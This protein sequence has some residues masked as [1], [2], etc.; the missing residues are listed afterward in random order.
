MGDQVDGMQSAGEPGDDVVRSLVEVL[1]EDELTFLVEPRRDGDQ[2]VAQLAAECEAAGASALSLSL[3]AGFGRAELGHARSGCQLPIIARGHVG[4]A[5]LVADLR[6][7]GADAIMTPASAWVDR[8]DDA[9]EPGD[10]EPAG[11]TLRGVVHAA[12]AAGIEVVLTVRSE[13]ELEFAI[14]TDVDAINI[15]N[16]DEDGSV[17]VDRTFELLA[18]VPAGWPVISESLAA[19]EQVARLHRAGVDALLLDEG[20]LDTGLSS[21][22]EVYA[23]ASREG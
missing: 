4:D 17:D 6:S 18:Q 16:R 20:H 11:D 14:D 9:P 2:P 7:A 22:L 5:M 3:D 23:H 15:D 13:S 12:R 21:A 19:L 1:S 10:D 8:G